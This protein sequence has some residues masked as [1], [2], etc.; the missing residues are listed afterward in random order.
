MAKPKKSSNASE[1]VAR[2]EKGQ[3]LPGSHLND[4]GKTAGALDFKTKWRIF[5]SKVA[6]QNNITPEEVEEQLLAV[7]FKQA[8]DA[9]FQFWKD[10]HDRVYDKAVQPFGGSDDGKPIVIKVVKEIA[11]QNGIPTDTGTGTDSA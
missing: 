7:G 2:N 10:I 6:T 8:K 11:D 1:K 3:L 9:N 4:A 5:I